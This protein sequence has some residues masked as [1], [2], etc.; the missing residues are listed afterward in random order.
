M[1]SFAGHDVRSEYPWVDVL[2]LLAMALVLA[3]ALAGNFW[4]SA[5]SVVLCGFFAVAMV[6]YLPYMESLRVY[7]G[8][9]A[10]HQAL[11]GLSSIAVGAALDRWRLDRSANPYDPW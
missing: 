4:L 10:I 8:A 5:T 1:P 6:F 2:W 3:T 11:F 9:G 7:N